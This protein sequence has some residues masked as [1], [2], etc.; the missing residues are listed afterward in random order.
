MCELK[1]I[2][3]NVMGVTN[4]GDAI[5]TAYIDGQ[6]LD[7]LGKLPGSSERVRGCQTDR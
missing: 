2:L 3:S 5:T 1:K 7:A 6:C 4:S